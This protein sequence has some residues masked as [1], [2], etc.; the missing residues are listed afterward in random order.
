MNGGERPLTRPRRRWDDN[1][2]VNHGEVM[3]RI[4]DWIHMAKDRVR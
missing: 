3:F 4:V 2:M 1:I